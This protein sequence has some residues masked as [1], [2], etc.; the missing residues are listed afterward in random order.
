M[1]LEIDIRAKKQRIKY[2][3]RYA[4]KTRKCRN[5]QTSCL[6]LA[7][8]A[9]VGFLAYAYMAPKAFMSNNRNYI[10]DIWE[11]GKNTSLINSTAITMFSIFIAL[12]IIIHAVLWRIAG[13]DIMTRYNESLVVLDREIH[14]RWSETKYWEG[15]ITAVIPFQNIEKIMYNPQIGLYLIQGSMAIKYIKNFDPDTDLMPDNFGSGV[16]PVYEYFQPRL[17]D[18]F[19]Q[20][21]VKIEETSREK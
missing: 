3:M 8:A 20:K 1:K 15:M 5:I 12:L 10:T 19:R 9:E 7:P 21:G 18:I 17:L 13:E 11:Y 16:F 6:L 4:L 14:Y 2:I